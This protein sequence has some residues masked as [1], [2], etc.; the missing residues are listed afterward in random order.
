MGAPIVNL[1][2]DGGVTDEVKANRKANYEI[3][4]LLLNRWSPRAMSGEALSDDELFPLFEAARWAPSSFNAQLWR[5][6]V[7]RRERREEFEKFVGLL[8]PGN[9]VWARNASALAVVVSS[10]RF[11]LYDRPSVTHAFD[12]GAAWENLAIE[13]AR[14]GLVAHG[15]EGFDYARARKELGVPDHF[16]V[17]AMLA[18]GKRAPAE[19]LP[20]KYRAAE[21]PNTRRPLHEIVFEAKFG[22]TIPGLP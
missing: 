15:M 12:T 14:R 1:M 18:I 17:H 21:H 2:N 10:T 16:E 6:I 22:Q 4:P 8:V 13:A 5:F 11:E 20:E 9:Q 7:G 3:S 19:S